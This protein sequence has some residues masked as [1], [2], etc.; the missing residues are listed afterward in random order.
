MQTTL[1]AHIDAHPDIQAGKAIAIVWHV[2]DLLDLEMGP[3]RPFPINAREASEILQGIER[4]HDGGYGITWEGIEDA[5]RTYTQENP[6]TITRAHVAVGT[7]YGSGESG[8]WNYLQVDIPS[9]QLEDLTDQ[10]ITAAF[11][12][13]AML[14][15]DDRGEA[16]VF[17]RTVAWENI[18]PENEDEHA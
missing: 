10:E 4:R 3:E 8:G 1:R 5:I 11:E 15:L 14:E 13:T 16:C 6:R 12:K 17:V 18:D 7:A 2:D 9:H